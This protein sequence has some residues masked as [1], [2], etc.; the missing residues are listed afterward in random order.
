MK[1]KERKRTPRAASVTQLHIPW[2]S[3]CGRRL[4]PNGQRFVA[5]CANLPRQ[6]WNL[7]IQRLIQMEF[8]SAEYVVFVKSCPWVTQSVYNF[9]QNQNIVKGRLKY[10]R[11]VSMIILMDIECS[12][13]SWIFECLVS[14]FFEY[15][16]HR[17]RTSI[18]SIFFSNFNFC[19]SYSLRVDT[20]GES[21][22]FFISVE[23]LR[24][25]C[26]PKLENF[27]NHKAKTIIYGNRFT[28]LNKDLQFKAR[29]IGWVFPWKFCR[30]I[31]TAG[32]VVF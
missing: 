27:L 21:V 2:P 30:V 9:L 32:Y 4:L 12:D 5:I 14:S 22:R 24:F 25:Y 3:A 8:L 15:N 7:R 18:F 13:Y 28:F 23:T 11:E 19:K 17:V 31:P 16:S 6:L 10:S 26:M 1:T 20:G 29:R